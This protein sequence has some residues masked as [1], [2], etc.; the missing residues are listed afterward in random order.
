MACSVQTA[1]NSDVIVL[2]F[3]RNTASELEQTMTGRAKKRRH[4]HYDEKEIATSVLFVWP[5]TRMTKRVDSGSGKSMMTMG[6][7]RL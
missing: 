2:L 6:E 7:L 4:G 3:G 5:L 1:K